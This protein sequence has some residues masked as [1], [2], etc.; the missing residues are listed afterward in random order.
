MRKEESVRRWV[1]EREGFYLKKAEVRKEAH[2]DYGNLKGCTVFEES[3]GTG[4]RGGTP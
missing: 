1:K 3:G 2:Q 4:D